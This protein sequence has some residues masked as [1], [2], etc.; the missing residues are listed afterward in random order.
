MTTPMAS[1][2]VATAAL[3]VVGLEKAF[4][5]VRAL[6][7]ADMTV[8]NGEVVALVGD[9]GAGKSTL[10]KCIAGIHT[11]DKGR[12][13]FDGV[14][15]EIKRPRDAS[16]LGIEV[17]YQD[18]ALADNLDVVR[19][20]YLGREAVYRL[21]RLN[22]AEM[23][24]RTL[25]TLN[26]LS[27][28]TIHSVR[29]TV[30]SLSGGQRQAVAVARALMWNSRVV[31]LDEPTAALGVEQTGQVLDVILRLKD[32]G[33][34]VV[35]ISHNLNDVFAVADFITVLH[36][37]KTVATLTR[38]DVTQSEVVEAITTGRIGSAPSR[39]ESA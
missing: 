9:N 5:A 4:G 32:H 3:T 31:I 39:G 35:V 36:L 30:G 1:Q 23:E 8:G 2:A 26:A 33:L 18:L 37:G 15:V 19:N 27:V 38:Q 6:R 14:P 24:Q 34:A 21:G 10:I 13:E 29:E 28:R 11:A 17:V 25:E 16:E 20:M 22:E 12:I 7:G